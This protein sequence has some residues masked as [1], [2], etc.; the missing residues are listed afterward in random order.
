MKKLSNGS[1]GLRAKRRPGWPTA[2][3]EPR[4]FNEEAAN[5]DDD[6]ALDVI[7][8]QLLELTGPDPV[9][10][11]GGAIRQSIDEVLDGPRTGRWDFFQLEKTEKTYVGTKVEI[12]VRTALKLEPG[13]K[14]DLEIEGH[15]LDIKWAM[16]SQWQIPREAIGEL[17]LCI[18]GRSRLSSFEVGLIRCTEDVLN[19]GSNQDGKRTISAEGRAA[20][21]VL[22]PFAPLPPNFVAELEPAMRE[23]VMAER[24][25]QRRVTKLF[26]L[27]PYRPIPRL[28]LQTVARTSGDPVRRTR[29]DAGAGDPLDG[30]VVLTKYGKGIVAALG[31]EPLPPNC[32]MSVPRSEVEALSASARRRL[33]ASERKRFQLN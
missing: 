8:D 5:R 23:E 22:V 31:F 24:T 11:F 9:G 25:I 6:A 26:K 14:L 1:S 10:L 21:R 17:C 3:R 16:N 29:A 2:T 7:A 19:R 18:G 15:D 4:L 32:F 33:S 13:P 20:M 12:V 30:M 28:A 27:L